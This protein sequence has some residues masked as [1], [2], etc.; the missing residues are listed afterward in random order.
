M[1]EKLVSVQGITEYALPN[2]LKVLLL[3][4]PSQATVTVNLTIFAGSACESYGE[5]GA[6][7]LLEHLAFQGSPDFENVPA[8]LNEHGAT[9]NGTT[10]NDR[11]NYYETMPASDENLEFGIHFEAARLMRSYIRQ[12]DLD[13]EM[14]V[15]RN[16][17]EAGENSPLG[18]LT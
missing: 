9:W 18:I 1:L 5:T 16:E 8:A 6:A 10:W 4:D 15:V 2:G 17:Y 11:T 13:S 7:H 12:A 14:T 3:P